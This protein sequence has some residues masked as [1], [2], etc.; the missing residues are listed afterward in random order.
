M[1]RAKKD[2]YTVLGVDKKAST[3]QIKKAYYSKS[4]KAH[5]DKGGSPEDQKDLNEAAVIL[6]DPV[7]RNQYDTTGSVEDFAGKGRQFAANIIERAIED[8][9]ANV[10]SYF[11]KVLENER[12]EVQK[13]QAAVRAKQKKFQKFLDRIE[14]KPPNDFVSPTIKAQIEQLE[15]MIK[16]GDLFLKSL[17]E[18]ESI[19]KEYSFTNRES[20]TMN[21]HYVTLGGFGL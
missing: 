19:L 9:P 7:K 20:M 1:G 2:P 21:K 12:S 18:A 5:P 10:E 11:K 15:T 13:K 3:E 4:K 16:E 17:D 14:K 6:L 8:D